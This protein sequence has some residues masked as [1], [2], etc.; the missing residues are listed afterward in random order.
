MDHSCC[1]SLGGNLDFLDFLQKKFYNIDCW[2]V[3]LNLDDDKLFFGSKHN[4][5]TFYMILF[6]LFDLILLFVCQIY[7]FIVLITDLL[8]FTIDHSKCC[9]YFYFETKKY[10][11]DKFSSFQ[12]GA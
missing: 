3:C 6:G 12:T 5:Y 8:A 4:I 7:V 9:P 1:F 10:F 2:A 11:Q